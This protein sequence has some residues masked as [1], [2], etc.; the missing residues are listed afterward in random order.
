MRIGSFR[1]HRISS[2]QRKS[3]RVPPHTRAGDTYPVSC[4][5][6]V[7]RDEQINVDGKGKSVLSLATLTQVGARWSWQT[8]RTPGQHAMEV[9][10]MVVTHSTPAIPRGSK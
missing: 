4:G 8:I 6:T 9:A 1:P 5:A 2:Y 3:R 7:R 10:H